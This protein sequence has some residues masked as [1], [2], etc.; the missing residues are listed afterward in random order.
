MALSPVG[1]K[2]VRTFSVWTVNTG[3]LALLST[4][5]LELKLVLLSSIF[6]DALL[7]LCEYLCAEARLHISETIFYIIYDCRVPSNFSS[8]Y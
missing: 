6:I 3:I 7:T 8:L 1:V 2:S 5:D 4:L